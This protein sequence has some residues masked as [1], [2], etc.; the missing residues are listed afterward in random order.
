MTTILQKTIGMRRISLFLLLGGFA[1]SCGSY[2][3]A[4]L[5]QDGI[6]GQ[7][8]QADPYAGNDS[9]NY[10]EN[11]FA[12]LNQDMEYFTDVN[13]YNSPV[14]DS[15]VK[16]IP[17][18]AVSYGSWGTEPTSIQVNY[19]NNSYRPYWGYGYYDPFYDPYYYGGGWGMSIG[20][21]WGWNGYYRPWYNHHYWGS[22]YYGGYYSPYYAHGYYTNYYPRGSY[23]NTR[24]SYNT[25]NSRSY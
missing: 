14:N 5:A 9:G 16:N 22:P 15:I 25:N 18:K 4:S 13:T 11:Y 17:N 3:N 7:G 10:Y 2:Q 23:G 21:G 19:Y 8:T 6:Y 20:F 1:I 24:S 12:S